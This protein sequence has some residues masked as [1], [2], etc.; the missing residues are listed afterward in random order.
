MRRP[1][2]SMTLSGTAIVIG[3]QWRGMMDDC[4]FDGL[5][6]LLANGSSRRTALRAFA[7]GLAGSAMAALGGEAGAKDKIGRC[8]EP[9]TRCKQDREGDNGCCSGSCCQGTCCGENAACTDQ[10][11]C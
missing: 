4:R 3:R 9:G 6:R 8:G 1:V 10:G 2:A 7:V 5:T 11:C